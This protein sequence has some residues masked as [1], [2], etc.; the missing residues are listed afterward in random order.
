MQ[1]KAYTCTGM[2]MERYRYRHIYGDPPERMGPH[3][4]SVKV[5]QGHWNREGMIS[6]L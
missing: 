4:P 6:Y 3:V 2:Y 5:T 1:R